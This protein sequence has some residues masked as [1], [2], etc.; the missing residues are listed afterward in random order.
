[1]TVINV[2]VAGGTGQFGHKVVRALLADGGYQVNVLSR[3]GSDNEN[4]GNLRKQGANIVAVDYNH[5]DDLVQALQ[6]ADVLISTLLHYAAIELLPTLFRAAK[7]AGVR[8]VVPSDYVSDNTD[9]Q[10]AIQPDP[11]AIERAIAESQL[12]YTRYYCG[13]FY[14]YLTTPYIG[15]DLENHKVTI[16]GTGNTPVSLAHEDDF[17][18]FIAASLKDPRSK[19]A[20]L[21]FQSSSVTLLELVAALEK[22]VGAKLEVTH[23]PLDPAYRLIREEEMTDESDAI[24]QFGFEVEHKILDPS[25]ID[26]SICPSV[27]ITSLDTY[28]ADA[29]GK[30]HN[31]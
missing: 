13:V 27:H 20:K 1:M 15:V 30:Q 11:T 28:L 19:N 4:L 21:G 26:N 6:G 14:R 22:H 17:A 23:V 7:A 25:R 3:T 12:E 5:Y 2:T 10:Y 18:R 31:A 9:L 29:L 16:F 8:R 24:K